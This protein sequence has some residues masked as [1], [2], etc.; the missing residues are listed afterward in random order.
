MARSFIQEPN[1]APMAPLSWSQGIVG[2]RLAG[3]FFDERFE[4]LNQFLQPSGVNLR[5]FDVLL[6]GEQSPSSALR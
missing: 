5:V 4:P 1:T 6:A 3:A 2:E